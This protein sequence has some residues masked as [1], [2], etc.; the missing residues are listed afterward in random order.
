MFAHFLVPHPPFVINA[1]GACK[2]A[3]QARSASRR[4]NYIAQLKYTNSATLVLID[5]L[6]D[7]NPDSVII[8]QSDEGPWPNKYAGEEI[9]QFG[10]DVTLVDWNIVAPDD[11][12][13]KMAILNAIYLPGKPDISIKDDFS[14][15]NTFRVILRE[16]FG[17]P[18]QDLQTENWVYVSET[19]LWQ[20]RDVHGDLTGEEP[21]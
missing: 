13:E 4:D 9:T 18:L 20:F 8:L 1:D 5:T 17:R 16:Y 15:V 3:E 14:P 10:A 11:L 12:R 19:S 6:M 21:R 7:K 2:T